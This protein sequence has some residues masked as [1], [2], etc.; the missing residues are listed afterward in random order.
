MIA[1]LPRVCGYLVAVFGILDV[2][3]TY[4]YRR[5][6]GLVNSSRAPKTL[7]LQLRTPGMSVIAMAIAS[8]T[9]GKAT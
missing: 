8:T 7:P 9:K 6:A 5:A 4:R 1:Y 2:A 3:A